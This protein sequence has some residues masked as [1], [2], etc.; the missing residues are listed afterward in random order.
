M[1]DRSEN[2]E[3]LI[4]Q[5]KAEVETRK[6]TEK[7]LREALRRA[8]V[9]W[10]Q[11]FQ[12][13]G[14]LTLDGTMVEVNRAPLKFAGIEKTDILGRP[15]WEAPWFGRSVGLP[16][17]VQSAFARAIKG[18]LVRFEEWLR[19]KSGVLRCID[20]SMKPVRDESGEIVFVIAEGHD[21]TE[22]KRA[23][24]GRQ[25]SE[26]RLQAILDNSPAVIYLKDPQGRYRLINKTFEELFDVDREHFL[27]KSENS[28]ARRPAVI[29]LKHSP[30]HNLA[31][32][33][34]M[35]ISCNALN[36]LVSYARIG[37]C[38]RR[39]RS[40]RCHGNRAKEAVALDRLRRTERI[41]GQP[42]IQPLVDGRLEPEVCRPQPIGVTGHPIYD[43]DL[44]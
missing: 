14:L 37:E 10:E 24:Q 23:E 12:F 28:R 22:R 20:V 8:N 15:F 2:Q 6:A 43:R 38:L 19:G 3:Q 4:E 9:A 39:T 36:D 31:N 41:A 40:S 29:G 5:L 32:T 13:I 34:P 21:I 16:E 7:E 18:E 11:A 42:K 33:I 1:V 44:V 35:K 17:R 27:G 25:E 30:E 26:E